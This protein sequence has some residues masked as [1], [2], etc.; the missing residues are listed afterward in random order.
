MVTSPNSWIVTTI[1]GFIL[2]AVWIASVITP[3]FLAIGEP[4][5]GVILVAGLAALGIQLTGSFKAVKALA[6]GH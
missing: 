6:S 5:Q 2:L 3:P 1:A 4:L